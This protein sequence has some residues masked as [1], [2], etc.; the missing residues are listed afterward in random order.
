MAIPPEVDTEFKD[1]K[2]HEAWIEELVTFFEHVNNED[3]HVEVGI[4]AV[5]QPGH[6]A[7]GRL[8]HEIHDF[9]KYLSAKLGDGKVLEN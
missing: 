2:E 5:S 9:Q 4:Y 8:E 7:P 3:R 1:Q 6:A